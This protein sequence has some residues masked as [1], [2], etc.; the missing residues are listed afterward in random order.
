M[1]TNVFEI[2]IKHAGMNVF[3][4]NRVIKLFIFK[5]CAIMFY[6]RKKLQQKTIYI[7][8]QY[9]GFLLKRSLN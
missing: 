9:A 4:V 2:T 5:R 6:A 1:Q 8:K 7:F 3:L